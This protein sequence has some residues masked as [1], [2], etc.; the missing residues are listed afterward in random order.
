MDYRILF[1]LILAVGCIYAE[2]ST[3]ALC[4]CPKIYS[5]VCASNGKTYNSPC[6]FRCDAEDIKLK[7]GATIHIVR[8]GRCK[9]D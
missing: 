8:N 6:E 1:F 3:T 7:T 9:N 2:Q 5:P 4:A